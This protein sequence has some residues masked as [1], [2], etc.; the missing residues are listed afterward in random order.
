V[1]AGGALL[2]FWRRGAYPELSPR[3]PASRPPAARHAVPLALATG[4]LVAVLWVPLARWVPSLG[5]RG[6]FDAE[7]AGAG[8]APVLLAAR[9]FGSVVVV[10]FAEE[11]FVRSFLPRFVDDPDGW[12]ERP[13]GVFTR[14][15]AVVSVLFFTLSHPEWLAALVTGVLWTVLLVRTRRIGDVVLSHAVANAGLAAYVLATGDTSWW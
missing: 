12:R 3:G 11:L 14:L 9:L 8:L 4:L 1:L 6:G 2:W 10:P 15:S 7:A 13:V 5:G